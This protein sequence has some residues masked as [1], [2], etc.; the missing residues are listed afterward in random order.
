MISRLYSECFS[1]LLLGSLTTVMVNQEP[2]PGTSGMEK[3]YTLDGMA[4][5]GI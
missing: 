5:V 1:V 3:E 2:I 4:S